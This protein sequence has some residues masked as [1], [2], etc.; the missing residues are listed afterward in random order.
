MR[1]RKR[2]DRLKKANM[3]RGIENEPDHVQF[4]QQVKGSSVQPS[5]HHMP[6]TA[7]QFESTPRNHDRYSLPNDFLISPHRIIYLDTSRKFDLRLR[8]FFCVNV[9][10][11][12]YYCLMCSMIA[13]W[14][15][16]PSLVVGIKGEVM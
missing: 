7:T 4:L 12:K 15:A 5:S 9:H 14:M 6:T 10:M 1:S 13:L 16:N 8:N 2:R 3:N 11:L